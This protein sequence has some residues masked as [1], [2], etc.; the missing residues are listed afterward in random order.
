MTLSFGQSLIS[1]ICKISS[2]HHAKR[3]YLGHA[4]AHDKS[5]IGIN[6]FLIRR[7]NELIALACEPPSTFIGTR[8]D[9][10]DFYDFIPNI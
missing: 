7:K 2:A 5:L 10:I 1:L 9:F 3:V 4:R 6:L 8:N